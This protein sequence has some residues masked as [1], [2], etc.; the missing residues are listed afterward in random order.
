MKSI[1]KIAGMCAPVAAAAVLAAPASAA[2]PERIAAVLQEAFAGAPDEFLPRLVPDETMELCNATR[3]APDSVTGDRIM[4]MALESV[5][6]PED[7]DLLGDWQ[8]GER[9]AQSGYGMRFTD[10]PPA[11]E[12][13]GNCYACHQLTLHE[14]SYGTL[15]PSLLGYGRLNEF[16]E[17]ATRMVYERIWNPHTQLPCSMMPRFGANG[18]LSMDQIRDLVALLMDPESPVNQ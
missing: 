16:S 13:G 1:R 4:A 12:T 6:Y 11:R 9:L 3:N 10:Y 8:N 17:E 18:V 14:V 7:G 15:G 5:V 2:D